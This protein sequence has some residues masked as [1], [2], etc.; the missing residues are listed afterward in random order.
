MDTIIIPADATVVPLIADGEWVGYTA[1]YW[2]EA[3]R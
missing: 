3:G 1:V 2:P